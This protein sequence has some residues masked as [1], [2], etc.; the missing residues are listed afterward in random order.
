MF[1]PVVAGHLHR[2]LSSMLLPFMLRFNYIQPKDTSL[3]V[4]CLTGSAPDPV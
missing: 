4:V 2:L 1:K 3:P